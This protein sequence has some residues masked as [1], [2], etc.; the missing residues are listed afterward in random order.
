MSE[1]AQAVIGV[2]AYQLTLVLPNTDMHVLYQ[3]LQRLFRNDRCQP[4]L[5]LT[6]DG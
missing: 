1:E 2:A 6:I 3:S 5:N 4:Y